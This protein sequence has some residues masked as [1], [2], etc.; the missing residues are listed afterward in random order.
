M[1]SERR[2]EDTYAYVGIFNLDLVPGF[3]SPLLVFGPCYRE[4]Y[5]VHT[6]NC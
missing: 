1:A 4:L 6:E 2:I 5:K 3:V